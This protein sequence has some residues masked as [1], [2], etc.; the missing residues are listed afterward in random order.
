MPSINIDDLKAPSVDQQLQILGNDPS[1]VDRVN[2]MLGILQQRNDKRYLEM[3]SALT[4]AFAQYNNKFDKIEMA[5]SRLQDYVEIK[6]PYL[7]GFLQN[8]SQYS[9]NNYSNTPGLFF[10]RL[11]SPVRTLFKIWYPYN[12]KVKSSD[13]FRR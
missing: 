8:P 7:Y 3:V 12:T 4:Y 11:F 9:L 1:L 13:A 6:H 2:L 5:C 10:Y